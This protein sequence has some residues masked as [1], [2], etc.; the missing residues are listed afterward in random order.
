MSAT[1]S[2][3]YARVI[4][5]P[6]IIHAPVDVASELNRLTVRRTNEFEDL[7]ERY[8][9]MI[10][11]AE[12]NRQRATEVLESGGRAAYDQLLQEWQGRRSSKRASRPRRA[13]SPIPAEP[14]SAK[15]TTV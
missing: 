10:L 7:P 8:Q 5:F 11:E 12:A 6:P 9:R 15:A 14:A 2:R 3:R 13:T 1:L 4:G